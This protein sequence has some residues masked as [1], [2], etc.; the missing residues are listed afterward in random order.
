MSALVSPAHREQAAYLRRV[1]DA[2]PA[3]R[4]RVEQVLELPELYRNLVLLEMASLAPGLVERALRT[5]EDLGCLACSHG[6]HLPRECLV[7]GVSADG[8]DATYCLCPD[9]PAVFTE[10]EEFAQQQLADRAWEAHVD[11]GRNAA[12]EADR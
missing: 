8:R 12:A 9:P 4:D 2:P 10:Q 1:F 6:R 5:V 3:H 11:A 7:A